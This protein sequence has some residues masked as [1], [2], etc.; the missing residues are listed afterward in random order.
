MSGYIETSNIM[1]ELTEGVSHPGSSTEISIR[2][3]TVDNRQP[4]IMVIASAS[5]DIEIRV[6][7]GQFVDVAAAGLGTHSM[8]VLPISAGEQI[9]MRAASASAVVIR[10]LYQHPR[11]ESRRLT[12]QTAEFTQD[13]TEARINV[14]IN[15]V[16]LVVTG[17]S[18]SV[19]Y[20]VDNYTYDGGIVTLDSSMVSDA[21]PYNL[22]AFTGHRMRFD[23]PS[24]T[25]TVRGY[26]IIG[27][28]F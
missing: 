2:P 27:H 24:G 8:S 20:R 13:T 28:K 15:A 23:S 7:A 14:P 11:S 19:S 9:T 3:P 6:G 12:T 10:W 5:A 18:G 21:Y 17:L 1:C 4:F 25:I 26:W 16:E 22:P